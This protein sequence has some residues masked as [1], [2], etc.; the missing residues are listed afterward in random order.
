M[1]K[2]YRLHWSSGRGPTPKLKWQIWDWSLRV[3]VAYLENRALGRQICKLLNDA[4][5]MLEKA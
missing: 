2:R 5:L 1:T 3:P 4:V